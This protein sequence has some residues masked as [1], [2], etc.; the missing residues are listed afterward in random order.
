MPCPAT[1]QVRPYWRHAA[2]PVAVECQP[3]LEHLNWQWR[4]NLITKKQSPIRGLRASAEGK[5]QQDI[6]NELYEGQSRNRNARDLY[7]AC[8]TIH[9]GDYLAMVA[10]ASSELS[11]DQSKLQTY[12]RQTYEGRQGHYIELMEEIRK[13]QLVGSPLEQDRAILKHYAKLLEY[14]GTIP[15]LL[16]RSGTNSIGVLRACFRDD[17]Q[18]FF[19]TARQVYP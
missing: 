16:E 11:C 1:G 6:L 8:A 3:S 19:D 13:A 12:L 15:G 2:D 18:N 5:P 4:V 7:K 14:R 17:A 10:A 9:G